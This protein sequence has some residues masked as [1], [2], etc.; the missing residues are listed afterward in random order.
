MY[1][2]VYKVEVGDMAPDFTLPASDG[3]KV[4]LYDCKNRKTV[5]LFFF[6]H[7]DQRCR[8]RLSGLARD[9]ARFQE[10]G[11]IIFPVALLNVGEGK[12][13][14]DNLSLPFPILCDGD[15]SVA[16]NYRVGQC[17]NEAQHVCFEIISRVTDP[18]LIVVDPSGIIR[19]KHH[20]AAPGGGAD[21][22]TLLLEC[23]QALR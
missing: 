1:N 18:Q 16:Y 14:V 23:Q 2:M 8:D 12:K 3:K 19:F 22:G 5:V 7:E 21:N 15:H 20:L 11:A 4:R 9:Y 6:D 10:E 17:S 13:L